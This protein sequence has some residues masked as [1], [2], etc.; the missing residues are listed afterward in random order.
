MSPAPGNE[1]TPWRF[2]P[3]AGEYMK[4]EAGSG[5][6]QCVERSISRQSTRCL[7]HT[8]RCGP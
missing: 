2:I 5:P 8:T 1:E 7:G 3:P 6:Q 4:V